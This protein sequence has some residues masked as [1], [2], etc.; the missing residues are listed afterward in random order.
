[1][2]LGRRWICGDYE[3]DAE[4]TPLEGTLPLTSAAGRCTATRRIG[5]TVPPGG[6]LVALPAR[7][8]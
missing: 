6:A 7:V 2:S 1:M 3:L 4:D 5:E 8:G